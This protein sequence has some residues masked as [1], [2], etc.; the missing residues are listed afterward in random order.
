MDLLCSSLRAVAEGPT[1]LPPATWS[2]CFERDGGG[3]EPRDG[4]SV[5][6]PA[7]VDE[8]CVVVPQLLFYPEWAGVPGGQGRLA[9]LIVPDVN[10]LSRSEGPQDE[11]RVLE[12]A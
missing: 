10:E 1:P 12:F 9:E 8:E 3:L 7:E 6:L 2:R 11:G 5:I 4:H